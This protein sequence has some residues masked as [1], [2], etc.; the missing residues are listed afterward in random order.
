M[1]YSNESWDLYISNDPKESYDLMIKYVTQ[2]ERYEKSLSPRKVKRLN[3]KNV[4]NIERILPIIR[5]YYKTNS[6]NKYILS[7]RTNSII[8][9]FMNYSVAEKSLNEGTVTPDHVIRIKPFPM[10]I[11]SKYLI[12]QDIFIKRIKK[13]FELYKKKYIS[14]FK[15]NNDSKNKKVMLD[16][17]PCIIYLQGL[18][19]ISI[20]SN[21]KSSKIAGELL[22]KILML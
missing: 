2:A 11:A 20:G 5:G 10:F 6:I 8:K 13:E 4:I 1:S 9:E 19:M 3:L 21:I 14:Y 22:N 18:G 17:Y 16:P 12:D 15:K 7:Y